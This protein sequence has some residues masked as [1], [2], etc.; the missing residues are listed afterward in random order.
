MDKQT[1]ILTSPAVRSQCS[2]M[3]HSLPCD[4]S[5]EVTIGDYIKPSTYE[6]Q[7]RM[8]I[9]VVKDIS[10][11]AWYDKRQM[12]VPQWHFIL[13]LMFLPEQFTEGITKKGY[14]KWLEIPNHE[15]HMVGS[16][17]MLTV[18][19]HSLYTVECTAF[20]ASLG[21]RFSSDRDIKF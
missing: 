19:G 8:F 2:V 1:Y 9:A 14:Q 15:P 21:V 10:S 12:N 5:I 3:L 13:K 4:G 20:G 11:Q 7:K 17:K 16:T 18:K 6:Q